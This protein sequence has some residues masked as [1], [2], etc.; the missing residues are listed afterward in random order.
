MSYRREPRISNDTWI[1]AAER[2]RAVIFKAVWPELEHGQE[3]YALLNSEGS[4]HRDEVLTDRPGRFAGPGSV[5]QSGE[6]QTDFP[7]RTA[8]DFAVRIADKLEEGRTHNEFGRLILVA[9]P[10]MLGAIREHLSAPLAKTVVL[11]IDKNL[12]A[13]GTAKV[14]EQVRCA[15]HEPASVP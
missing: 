3:I 2:G 14:M 8:T 5:R 11:E 13:N 9:S 1:L 4:A 7:H 6:P 10:M 15:C 12:I